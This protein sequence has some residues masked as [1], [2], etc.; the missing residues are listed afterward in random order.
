MNLSDK[1]DFKKLLYKVYVAGVNHRSNE[2]HS[3]AMDAFNR[4]INDESPLE[5]GDHYEIKK[6]FKIF[7]SYVPNKLLEKW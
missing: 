7:S 2:P 3:V 4:L 6:N 5:D 1:E